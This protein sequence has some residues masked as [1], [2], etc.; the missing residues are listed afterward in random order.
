MQFIDSKQSKDP[1]WIFTQPAA[2]AWAPC[3]NR[4]IYSP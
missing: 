1:W 2:H 4:T 3:R